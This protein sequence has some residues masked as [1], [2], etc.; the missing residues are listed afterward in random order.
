MS[1]FH[2]YLSGRKQ[3]VD[4]DGTQSDQLEIKTGVPQGSILGP[5]LFLVYMND[6]PMCSNIFKF[7][8]YADD[9]SLLNS[10]RV[11]MSIECKGNIEFINSEIS[12]IFDWLSV[13]KLSLNVKKTK[14]MIFRHRNKIIPDFITFQINSIPIERVSNFNFL[15]LMVNEY[16][17]WKPH[18][19][20][21]A[22]K[23]LNIS[24]SRIN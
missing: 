7:I 3:F 5:L 13:N 1:W 23:Y 16:L 11:S 22:S 2:S 21:T 12:K 15:G 24:V 20:K 14:Y 8:L 18:I 19:N 6:I 10:I 17:S 4:I 9:T